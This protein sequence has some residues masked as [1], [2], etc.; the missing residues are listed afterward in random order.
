MHFGALSIFQN[1]RD[2]HSDTDVVQG[3]LA[4]ARLSEASDLDS[5]W[6]VEHHFFPYSMCPDN[7]QYLAQV[8]GMTERIKLGT[9][10][11]IRFRHPLHTAAIIGTMTQL[12]GD[13]LILG[14]GAGTYDKTFDAVGLGGI[15]RPDLVKS[16]ALIIKKVLAEN[17]VSYK[18]DYFEFED[19]SI[20]PKGVGPV[21]FWYCGN[22]PASARR[23]VEYAEGWMPGRTTLKTVEAR[24]DYMQQLCE[25]SGREDMPTI[26]I[27]PPIDSRNA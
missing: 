17:N 24:R 9:G 12:L 13:R 7:L 18:D 5:Y 8:A 25:E 16:N 3:E 21:P 14:F 27:I 23:A 4:L 15:N 11:A 22:T 2:E 26:G 1:Y 6:A 10:S 20:E 19:I